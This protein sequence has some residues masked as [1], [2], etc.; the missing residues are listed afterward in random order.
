MTESENPENED[1]E[2]PAADSETVEDGETMEVPAEDD[3]D[4]D[5]EKRYNMDAYDDDEEDNTA[6][7]GIGKDYYELLDGAAI[8]DCTYGWLISVVLVLWQQF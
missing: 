6:G 1:T 8:L 7:L 4:D 3:N 2:N 5:F